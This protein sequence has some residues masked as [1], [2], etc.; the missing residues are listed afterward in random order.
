L[1]KDHTLNGFL[2][3]LTLRFMDWVGN[4]CYGI[5]LPYHYWSQQ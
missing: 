5:A 2:A 1:I 4:A 3:G